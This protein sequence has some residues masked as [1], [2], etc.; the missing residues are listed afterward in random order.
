MIRDG[1]GAGSLSLPLAEI[2]KGLA[3]RGYICDD[4]T[5]T[6]LYMAE[7]MGKPLLIEGPAV[8]GQNRAGQVLQPDAGEELD[9]A[10]VL[11]RT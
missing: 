6:V 5:A 3:H 7:K 2:K 10:A 11:R 8:V 1:T 4:T 9:Q